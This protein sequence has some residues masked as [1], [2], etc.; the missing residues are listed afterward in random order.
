MRSTFRSGCFL[1][2][3]PALAATAGCGG[4]GSPQPVSAT[5]PSAAP[6]PAVDD[7]PVVGP[8]TVA[9]EDMDRDQR[10]RYMVKVVMPTM[11]PLFKAFD[12]ARYAKFGCD[13][14]H[15][16]G[17]TD[18]TFAMPN[19]DILPLP[20]PGDQEKFAPIYQRAPKMVEFMGSQVMPE[21]ARLLGRE[22]FDYT[23]PKPDAFA[24][25]GCHTQMK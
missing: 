25:L 16:E 4:G 10:G 7:G 9:W 3:V 24:C 21:M 6:A 14:C 2:L 5:P 1:A 13:T 20:G 19:P 22:P 23:R 17:V 8:P 11:A 12:P 18:R 15:G